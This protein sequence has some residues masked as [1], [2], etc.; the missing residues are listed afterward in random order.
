MSE[1]RV[2]TGTYEELNRM[3]EAKVRKVERKQRDINRVNRIFANEKKT[4]E[5]WKINHVQVVAVQDL[6]SH[7]DQDGNEKEKTFEINSFWIY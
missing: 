3:I 7:A 5:K 2:F 1:E 6:P 4:I